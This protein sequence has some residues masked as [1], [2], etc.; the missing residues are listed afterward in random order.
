MER[1]ERTDDRVAI[2]TGAS[3]GIGLAVAKRWV[4]RGQRAVLVARSGDTLAEI[5]KDLGPNAAAFR[6]DVVDLEALAALPGKVVER[7][8]RLDVV[9]NNAGVN[10]RG[11]FDQFEPAELTQILMTNLVAPVVLSRAAVPVMERGGSIVQVASI[12]GM[13]P[14]PGEATYSASKAGLRAFARAAAHD[15][16]GREI[17]VGC[18]CPG[19]VDTGFL[20][21]LEHVPDIVLSQPM[22]SADDV[23][24]AVLRCIDERLDEIALPAR[25]GRLATLA[26]LMPAFA[27]RIRPV[28]EKRGSRN[29]QALLASRRKSV[30]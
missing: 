13:V 27:E 28:L 7:F 30:S 19:P 2:I 20:R 17:H 8:G 15:V 12:A 25:T 16:A 18:V 9:V 29:K 10:H 23:A 14:V 21:D 3:S 24:Q 22:V 6:L 1:T 26:Y 5:A 11:P 4:E